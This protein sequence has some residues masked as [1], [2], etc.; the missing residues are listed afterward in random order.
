MFWP[1][2]MTWLAP[3]L[4]KDFAPSKAFTVEQLADGGAFLIA[5]QET[6]DIE[7]P[8]H[9]VAAKAIEAALVPVEKKLLL[10]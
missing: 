2:W 10:T 4:A 9:V 3:E 7:N 5:T 6:F 1:T 8:E